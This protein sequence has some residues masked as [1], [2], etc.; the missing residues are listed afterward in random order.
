MYKEKVCIYLYST[1]EIFKFANSSVGNTKQFF[2]YHA[3]NIE[4]LNRKTQG[5]ITDARKGI[6]AIKSD[7]ASFTF[8]K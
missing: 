2:C 7:V 6:T 1:E 8:A 5:N 3:S 4:S